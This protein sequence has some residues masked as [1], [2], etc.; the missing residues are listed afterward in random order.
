MLFRMD[1]VFQHNRSEVYPCVDS[2]GEANEVKKAKHPVTR[3]QKDFLVL[4]DVGQKNTAL[5]DFLPVLRKP[6]PYFCLF[7]LCVNQ[8][9]ADSESR[10]FMVMRP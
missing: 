1:K 10:K 6:F 8:I 3:R 4:F 9:R 7:L 2:R 5:R